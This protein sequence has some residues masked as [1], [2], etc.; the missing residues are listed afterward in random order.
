MAIQK[1]LIQSPNTEPR[2]HNKYHKTA[3]EDGVYIGRG[4]P[5]GN[6]YVIG[7]HGTREEVIRLF[8]I[9]VLPKLDVSQLRGKHLVCFCKP[10]ACHGD[11][12]LKK[13][14]Q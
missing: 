11:L 4:S 9:H 10:A 6:P 8:E 2:V 12:I 5:Y 14:N 3:P 1:G 7:K 13:A